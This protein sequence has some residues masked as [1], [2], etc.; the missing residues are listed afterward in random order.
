MSSAKCRPFF[1]GVN[2]RN[3]YLDA[4]HGELSSLDQDGLNL[5]SELN[6]LSNFAAEVGS[7]FGTYRL[8]VFWHS[9]TATQN[10]SMSNT[11]IDDI[12]KNRWWT[13]KIISALFEI[14]D[15]DIKARL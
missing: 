12:S 9:L 3:S 10:I 1:S 15:R 5:L 13:I 4:D 11:D 14:K 8:P 2:P 7:V 6:Q